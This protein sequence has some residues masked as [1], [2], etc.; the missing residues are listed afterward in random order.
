VSKGALVI[1]SIANL[2][3]GLLDPV[4]DNN[5]TQG[6]SDF[7][8]YFATGHV[9]KAPIKASVLQRFAPQGTVGGI[10]IGPSNIAWVTDADASL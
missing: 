1:H 6:A 8:R 9:A 2:L 4:E 3:A 5:A 7:H 10:D